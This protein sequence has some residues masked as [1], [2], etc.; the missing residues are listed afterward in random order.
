MG[1]GRRAKGK[2]RGPASGPGRSARGSLKRRPEKRDTPKRE[3]APRMR[4]FALLALLA[5]VATPSAVAQV[6]V[7]VDPPSY[8]ITP[9]GPPA[10]LPITVE[11]QCG[12][13]AAAN[14]IHVQY[15]VT[16]L[17]PWA[18]ATLSPTSDQRE[19]TQCAQST[20]VFRA[21]A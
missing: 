7:H 9:M 8:A 2:G 6:G 18:Q 21:V 13:D 11:V 17:P 16:K 20:A 3:D 4:A 19:Y 10:I 12:P 5:L 1:G 15:T 14:G